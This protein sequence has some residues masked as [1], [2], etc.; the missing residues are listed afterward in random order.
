[1]DHRPSGSTR[2]YQLFANEMEMHRNTL[3]DY[4]GALSDVHLLEQVPG[5]RPGLDKRETDKERVFVADPAF[6]AAMLPTDANALMRN[7]DA[8]SALLETFVA[9]EVIRLLTW[10]SV[11]AKLFH[12]RD[13]NT[14]EVDLVLERRDG[15]LIGIEVKAARVAKADHL[16]GLREL[17][18]RYPSRFSGAL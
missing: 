9:T 6:V 7:T 8:F 14:N 12:W 16:A 2:N 3:S 10:S 5:Y 18:K 4:L 1:M 13:S 17:Y 15:S 11:S